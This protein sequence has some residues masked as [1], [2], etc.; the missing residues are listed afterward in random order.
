[1]MILEEN[2]LCVDFF[3]EMNFLPG[4]DPPIFIYPFRGISPDMGDSNTVYININISICINM[5]N[6]YQNTFINWS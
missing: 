2:R 4:R 6:V 5:Y 1:M 3:Y